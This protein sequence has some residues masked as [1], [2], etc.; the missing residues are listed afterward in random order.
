GAE[1]LFGVAAI[2]GSFLAGMTLSNMQETS[3]VSRRIDMSA[4]MLFSPIFFANIGIGMPFDQLVNNFSWVLVGF[5][6]AFVVVGLLSKFIGCG[7]GSAICKYKPNQCIKVGVGMM[8]RGEVC[9]IVAQTGQKVGLIQEQ[10]FPAIILLIITSSVLV[11]IILKMMFKKYPNELLASDKLGSLDT[12]VQEQAHLNHEEIT[13]AQ[14]DELS[15]EMGQEV[16][17][18]AKEETPREEEKQKNAEESNSDIDIDNG[19]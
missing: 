9:L 8:V 4:Y 7:I 11:P 17:G 19:D 3:Y 14:A 13:I 5:S 2:T 16:F 10:Y 6:V 12:V 18:L 15:D 1:E